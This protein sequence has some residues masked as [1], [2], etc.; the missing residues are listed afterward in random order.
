MHLERD[1]SDHLPAAAMAGVLESRAALP[2]AFERVLELAHR[3]GT[4][5]RVRQLLERLGA[6]LDPG[7]RDTARDRERRERIE[8]PEAR[9]PRRRGQKAQRPKRA[10]P[11]GGAPRSQ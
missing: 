6:Y 10:R 3:V 9:A 4:D 1:L 11:R 5:G 8:H 2:V 7:V